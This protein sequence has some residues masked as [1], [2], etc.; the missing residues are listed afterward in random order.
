MAGFSDTKLS[1]I[2]LKDNVFTTSLAPTEEV[3]KSFN[4]LNA[5]NTVRGGFSTTYY[6]NG[7]V[8]TFL[9]ASNNMV[10][11]GITEWLGITVDNSGVASLN[12][13]NGIR[14]S[15]GLLSFP[16]GRYIDL[17]LGGRSSSYTAPANGWFAFGKRASAAGQYFNV[18]YVYPAQIPFWSDVSS[19]ANNNILG[20]L[21]PV[22][23]G[24][25]IRIDYNAGGAITVCRFIYAAGQPNNVGVTKVGALAEN[26]GVLSGFSK[27]NYAVLPYAFQPGSSPW[28]IGFKFTTGNDVSTGQHIY[29]SDR[30][31]DVGSLYSPVRLAVGNSKFYF[32]ISPT[33]ASET[34]IECSTI[35]SA[36]TTY[37]TKLVFNGSTYKLYIST[38]G[39]TYTEDG[40]FT[41]S[42]P[43]YQG[44]GL[45]IGRHCNQ[46][47]PRQFLGTVD[48]KESYIMYNGNLW[49][50]GT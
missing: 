38:D 40:S 15:L 50:S 32:N 47:V 3:T 49:W 45:I 20:H 18:I 23:K 25:V 28:E 4:V 19:G 17:A 2:C 34:V 6:T 43:V 7:S 12:A 44:L 37:Y 46:D 42:T 41:S 27:D 10:G 35:I 24:Q 16:S 36:N 5:D 26:A 48:L 22:M 39:V 31:L 30:G 21:V 29:E 9:H 14:E 1:S 11:K 13:S 8:S 33:L